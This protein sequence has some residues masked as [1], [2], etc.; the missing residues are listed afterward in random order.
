[1]KTERLNY[2]LLPNIV[3][4]ILSLLFVSFVS[5]GSSEKKYILTYYHDETKTIWELRYDKPKNIYINIVDPFTN[6][7]I[8]QIKDKKSSGL[9]YNISFSMSRHNSNIVL[10]G[11][12]N[13]PVF[14]VYNT[15]TYEKISG[16]EKL[17]QLDPK[18][19]NSIASISRKSIDKKYFRDDIIE[20]KAR[21]YTKYF[22][23]VQRALFF[24]SEKELDSFVDKTDYEMT[25][26]RL[27][28]FVLSEDRLYAVTHQGKEKAYYFFKIAG[29]SSFDVQ[30]SNKYKQRDCGK[31]EVSLLSD[32]KFARGR[33]IYSNTSAAVISHIKSRN[34]YEEGAVSTYF[35]PDKKLFQIMEK[36]Y[37]NFAMMKKNNYH[38]GDRVEVSYVEKD[39]QVILGFWKYGALCIDLSAGRIIWK[40]EPEVKLESSESLGM[41]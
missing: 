34:L 38:P 20:I 14:D 41:K 17:E 22:Y 29:S 5:C 26:E 4:G 24:R 7:Q 23:D 12:G 35:Y 33:I 15:N 3:I 30:Y 36:D 25:P 37:P 32:E 13:T 39:S 28:A 8:R 1:M 18:L 10:I 21:D 19:K 27:T 40:F 9:D 2:I 6:K 11:F 16:S 31:C